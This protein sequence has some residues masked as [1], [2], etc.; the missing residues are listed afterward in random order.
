M[1]AKRGIALNAQILNVGTQQTQ[2]VNQVANGALVHTRHTRKLHTTHLTTSGLCNGQ[3]RND[4][5][6]EG[7]NG[8][9]RVANKALD[10]M[11]RATQLMGRITTTFY[12][13]S[14]TGWL[15]AYAQLTQGLNHDL[16]VI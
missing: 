6:Q 16:R 15:N 8:Q 9:P 14:L 11:L 12:E 1:N 3:K 10:R 4:C 7:T 13:P 5:G 2:A